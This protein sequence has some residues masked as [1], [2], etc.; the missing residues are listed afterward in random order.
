MTTMRAQLP[1]HDDIPLLSTESEKREQAVAFASL[2]TTMTT[3]VTSRLDV[4]K[5]TLASCGEEE[6]GMYG[7]R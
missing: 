1:P 2:E 5:Q 7:F 3:T 6:V 4:A